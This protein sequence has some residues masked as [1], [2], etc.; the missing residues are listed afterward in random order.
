MVSMELTWKADAS[1]SDS[2]L[3][4]FVEKRLELREE[5]VYMKNESRAL[6]S[7]FSSVFSP[8]LMYFW[9][10]EQISV[11]IGWPIGLYLAFL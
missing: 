4:P 9:Y 5:V 7:I 6:N 2:N 1:S 3:W 8:F 11:K 10:A